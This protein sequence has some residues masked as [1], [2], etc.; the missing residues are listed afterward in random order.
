[1]TQIVNIPR[2]E[3]LTSKDKRIASYPCERDYFGCLCLATRCYSV[4]CV[5]HSK[6]HHTLSPVLS[7]CELSSI[8]TQSHRIKPHGY[9]FL[10]DGSITLLNYY[11]QVPCEQ[12]SSKFEAVVQLH[13][14]SKTRESRSRISR[15]K[16]TDLPNIVAPSTAC[17]TLLRPILT[18]FHL[19]ASPRSSS[20]SQLNLHPRMANAC[21]RDAGSQLSW[22]CQ[23]NWQ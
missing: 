3:C 22:G 4:T 23:G 10:L 18:D 20:R 2:F 5:C 6:T 8:L 16:P 17:V 15:L 1:M 12:K 14:S 13:I 19:L 9:L 7:I 11:S 21:F